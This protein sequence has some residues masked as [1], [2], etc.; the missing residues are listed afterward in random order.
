VIGNYTTP[1]VGVTVPGILAQG[2][3]GTTAVDLLPYFDGGF[4][5]SNRGGSSGVAIN[6]LDD[7]GA[8]PLKLNKPANGTT[9]NQYM[10]LTHLYEYFGALLGCSMQGG[11]DYPAYSGQSSQY[12]VH[13]F[14]KLSE[15][16]FTYFVT[17]VAL[18][19]MSFGVA[20]DDIHTVGTAL[21]STFGFMCESAVAVIPAQG[22]QLQSICTGDGCPMAPNTTCAA[23]NTTIPEPGVANSSL[24]PS[25]TVSGTTKPTGSVTGTGTA[26]AASTSS[27]KNAAA[28]N[29]MSFAAVAGGLAAMFL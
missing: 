26:T 13:K 15:A 20:A 21:N 19:A 5:S 23:S 6:F 2:T 1:N 4:A 16:E 11:A 7:G 24:V 27:T 18:S 10:L 28:V 8:A 22:A 3:V 14:M 9:S 29:G 25:V 17:Q 12:N